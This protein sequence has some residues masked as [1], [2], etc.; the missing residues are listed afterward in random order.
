MTEALKLSGKERVLEVGTG[1]GYQSAILAE[2][3]AA[4]YTVERIES[5]SLAARKVLTRLGYD[6]IF[7]KTGDGWLG[8]KKEAPFDA[9]MVTAAPVSVPLALKEQ[10]AVGGRMVIPVG[11]FQ[12]ELVLV[13]RGKKGYRTKH[14]LPVRFVPLVKNGS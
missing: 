9:I 2:I 13:S 3:V 8:W 1:S 14:L 6:N 5:L 7:F 10:L 4:V 12:Q 11:D